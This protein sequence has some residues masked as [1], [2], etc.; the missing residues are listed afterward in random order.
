MKDRIV[1]VDLGGTQIRAVLTDKSGNKIRRAQQLTHAKEGPEAV[2][3]RIIEII[4]EVLPD[5]GTD[6][7]MGIGIGTPGP[8]DPTTG[9]LYDP[10]NLPGW[11]AI[12]LADRIEAAFDRPAFVGND[13][14]VAALG[15]FRFG[16]GA[17]VDDLVYITVSTG[18]GGG[19]VSGSQLI[20]GARGFAGEIGHQ[21]LDPDGPMCGC[22]QPGHL[23]AFA[24][25][26]SIARDARQTLRTG[27]GSMMMDMAGAIEGVTAKIVAQA[28]TQGDELALKIL[29]RAAFYIGVGLTNVIH[30]VEPERIAIGGGVSQ[31]GALLFEPIRETVNDRLMSNVYEGVEIVPATLGDDVGL[32]GAVALVLS[33]LGE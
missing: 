8:V 7:V 15:E 17:D 4:E 26:P 19:I 29:R 27:T 16:A 20:T 10:P 3:E 6:R 22:G 21:T 1:G 5:A 14:N 23:E 31:A 9:T 32:L 2:I 12:S 18:I 13:A 28:A 11:K 30:I 24:S 33:E 25:G